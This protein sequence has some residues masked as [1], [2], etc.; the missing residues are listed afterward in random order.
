MTQRLSFY[1]GLYT[2]ELQ[3]G[4]STNHLP[5]SSVTIRGSIVSVPRG[6]VQ[7]VLGGIQFHADG[8]P[9]AWGYNFIRRIKNASGEVLWENWNARE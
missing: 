9:F 7:Q 4:A 5:A 3:P 1:Q 8:K 6:T 2:V